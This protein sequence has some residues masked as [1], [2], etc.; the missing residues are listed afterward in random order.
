MALVDEA[1]DAYP[2]YWVENVVEALSPGEW[3]LD[4]PSGRL[5]YAPRAGER[6]EALVVE[7]PVLTS[8]L[9]IE[10]RPE[11][12]RFVE[13]L[14]FLGIAFEH[15]A[16]PEAEPAVQAAWTTPG[17]L[18]LRG[19]RNVSIEDG[20][21][22]GV[23]GYAVEIGPGC[24]DVRVVGNEITD[25]GAGGVKVDGSDAEGDPRLRTTTVAIT[26]N[27]VHAIGRVLPSAIGV[28]V[29]HAADVEV[30]HNHIHDTFYTA[31][32]AGW[33]W[34][35]TPSV[36]RAIRIERNHIHDVGQRVLSDMGGVY[37]LGIQPGSVVRGN[38]VHGVKAAGYGGWAIYPDEGSSHLVIEDNVAFDTT[39]HVFHQHYGNENTVR[40][41]VFAF[42]GEGALA[43]SRGPAHNGGRGALAFTLERNI[44][45]SDGRPVI[46]TG[47][48]GDGAEA[49]DRAF[50][51]DL[52]LL[53]DASGAPVALGDGR[54]AGQG[55]L[56]KAYDLAGWQALGLD[57]HS[58]AADPG[59][60]DLARRDLRLG[61]DS[62]ALALGFR[63]IDL[64]GVGPRPRGE[65]D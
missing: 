50:L 43:L 56:R 17:T 24:R 42:G 51:S 29:R 58:L 5:H 53:W 33:V 2:R 3:Y 59:F 28:L 15:A 30:A 46:A 27:H 20:R 26:D 39:G 8:L 4:R 21:V 14:R 12:D 10:G 44:L 36:T 64:A 63:P 34:G 52:N 62:P 47:L 6:P 57:R 61:P 48:A 11:E 65:R 18:V 31:I 32:S 38:L 7:V 25:V 41:N 22:G 49:A 9:R 40:N 35:Y 45:V 13:G 19:A 55:G 1:G 60:A 23:G 16:V 54:G 37:T